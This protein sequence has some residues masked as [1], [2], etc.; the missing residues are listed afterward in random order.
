[1]IEL[2]REEKHGSVLLRRLLKMLNEHS[3]SYMYSRSEFDKSTAM[4]LATRSLSL[5]LNAFDHQ[6]IRFCRQEARM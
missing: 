2:S 4:Q 1:L 6:V 5:P 3:I